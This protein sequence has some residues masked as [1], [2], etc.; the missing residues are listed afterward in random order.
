MGWRL[1]ASGGVQAV[2]KG[3]R[4]VAEEGNFQQRHCNCLLQ[5]ASRQHK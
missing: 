1:G 4:S 5:N 2:A 3:G